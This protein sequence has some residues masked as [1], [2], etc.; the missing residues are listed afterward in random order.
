MALLPELGHLNRKK[1]A[2]LVGV[3]PF[4]N[5]SGK[6]RGRRTTW[7]GR[8]AVRSVL[9]MAAVVA[10]THNPLIRTLYERLTGRGKP[11]KVALIAC[12]RKLLTVL[13]AMLRDR[14]SSTPVLAT[15]GA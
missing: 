11:P 8:A 9:Y 14:R 2:A 3:A 13:N 5:D 15:Q 1:I 12:T 7:G 6:K 4:N 10:R